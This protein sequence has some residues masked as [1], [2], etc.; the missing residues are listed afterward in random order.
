LD[1]WID[2]ES[3]SKVEYPEWREQGRSVHDISEK[4][5]RHLNFFQNKTYLHCRV[6]RVTYDRCGVHQVRVPWARE[7][8]VFT[9]LTDAFILV[10]VQDMPV[11]RVAEI[12]EEHD[13]RIWRI[14]HHYV[15]EGRIREDFSN[16][17]SIGIDEKSCARSHQYITVVVDLDTSRIIH[18]CEGR[19]AS[20]VQSFYLDFLNH[21][22]DPRH[23]TSIC[24]DMSPAYIRGI[25]D[26]FP[27]SGII[28]DKFHVMK[29]VNQAVDEVRRIEQGVTVL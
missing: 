1:I 19:S 26:N 21:R 13:T 28:L 27:E 23:V 5:W 10:M 3:G 14:I 12:I 24:C 2:F 18:V 11:K 22:G 16:I 25:S 29:I 4:T 8:S 6:P 17:S 20:T 7:Q 9:L 15:E